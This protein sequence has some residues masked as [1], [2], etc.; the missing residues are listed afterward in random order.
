[1]KGFQTKVEQEKHLRMRLAGLEPAAHG[2]IETR[3]FYDELSGQFV[4]Q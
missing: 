1:M 2:R 3:L 4:L